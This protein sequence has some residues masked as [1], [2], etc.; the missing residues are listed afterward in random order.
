MSCILGYSG[1][2]DF[3]FLVVLMYVTLLVMLKIIVWDNPVFRQS[4]LFLLCTQQ[5]LSK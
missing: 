4:F 3:E 2:I 1:T 5:Q